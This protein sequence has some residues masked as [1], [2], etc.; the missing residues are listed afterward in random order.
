MMRPK[1]LAILAAVFLILISA[2][3][4]L[5]QGEIPPPYAGLENPFPWDDSTAQEAGQSLYQKSCLGCHGV[6]GNNISGSDFSATDYPQRLEDEPD[7]YFW[8]LSEGESDKGM[9]AFKSSLTEE[10]RW[11]LLT[12]LW[13]LGGQPPGAISPVAEP[14][15]E[16]TEGFLRLDAPGQL[17]AGQPFTITAG[18]QDK[19]GSPI[20]NAQI[21]FFIETDFFISGLMEVG[22]ALTN[23]RGVAVFE[24]TPRLAQDTELVARHG[25][26]E[27][28]TSIHIAE[29]AEGFYQSEAGIPHSVAIPEVFAGPESALGPGED[30]SAPTT[31]LRI[32]SGLES[33]LLMSYVFAVVL[34]W[35]LYLRI[36]YQVSRIPGPRAFGEPNLKVMPWIAFGIGAA[37]LVLLVV[38]IITGPYSHPH[39]PR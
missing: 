15:K 23:E 18:L 39:L 20:A 22:E 19:E 8:I 17:Q 14:P 38:I 32:P 21:K 10:E 25:N 35:G 29:S 30:G 11:Q 7:L 26:I 24:Y 3:V 36:I 31:G 1:L 33:V 12:Y 37:L 34:V 6:E 2:T 13:S 5:A 16:V 27:A 4:V 28:T 9:P